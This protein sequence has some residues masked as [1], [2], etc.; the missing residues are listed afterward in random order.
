[1]IKLLLFLLLLYSLPQAVLAQEEA[2]P[3]VPVFVPQITVGVRGGTSLSQYNF[4]PDRPQELTIGYTGGFMFKHLAHPNVGVQL[5]LNLVQR[6]WTERLDQTQTFSR[7]MN[8]LELPFMT[9]VM[10]GKRNTRAFANLGPSLAFLLSNRDSI[11]SVRTGE[12]VGYYQKEIESPLQFGLS[13]G[14]GVIQ[15]TPVGA[16]QL[17]IRATQSLTSIFTNTQA[18]TSATNTNV[19]VSLGYLLDFRRSRREE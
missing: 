15:K 8:Y 18:V 10:L 16:F 14:L 17:E 7:A 4:A 11:A 5:E 13:V 12:D 19:V 6:G 9:H 3:Q 2:N 1:M